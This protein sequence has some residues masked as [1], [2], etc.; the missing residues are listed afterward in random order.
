MC[1]ADAKLAD[2]GCSVLK[3]QITINNER[4]QKKIQNAHCSLRQFVPHVSMQLDGLKCTTK[5]R[6]CVAPVQP[7]RFEA[8]PP[9][10][11]AA[12][13]TVISD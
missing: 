6:H 7:N 1:H 8:T 3:K 4:M 2:I 13:L 11:V 5:P 12:S 9:S 10:T